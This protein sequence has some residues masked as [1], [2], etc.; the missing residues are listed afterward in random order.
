LKGVGRFEEAITALEQA[1]DIFRETGDR[2]TER[3]T[4]SDLGTVLRQVQRFEEAITACQHDIA[5]SAELAD[6]CRQADALWK[7][8]SV[9]LDLDEG[10][11]TPSVWTAAARLYTR[12]PQLTRDLVH[13][14]AHLCWPAAWGMVQGPISPSN[15]TAPRGWV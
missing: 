7:L 13:I 8:G 10:H 4:W 2:H 5:I 9:Y 3:Q 6:A 11:W 1:G 14:R 15:T 12:V